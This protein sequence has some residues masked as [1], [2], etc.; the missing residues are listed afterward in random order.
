MSTLPG[1]LIEV[2]E[3]VRQNVE[4]VVADS[5]HEALDTVRH[6]ALRGEEKT[7]LHPPPALVHESKYASSSFL[8]GCARRV[9]LQ[10]VEYMEGRWKPLDSCNRLYFCGGTSIK[11]TRKLTRPALCFSEEHD[12]G[13]MVWVIVPEAPL[14]AMEAELFEPTPATRFEETWLNPGMEERSWRRQIG[15]HLR[16]KPVSE[17]PI[18]LLSGSYHVKRHGV[19]PLLRLQPPETSMDKEALET[20]CA[21]VALPNGGVMSLTELFDKNGDIAVCTVFQR[22]PMIAAEITNIERCSSPTRSLRTP[23]CLIIMLRLSARD[24]YSVGDLTTQDDSAAEEE[25]EEDEAEQVQDRH[26]N[27]L[28]VEH[29]EAAHEPQTTPRLLIK[30]PRSLPFAL[31]NMEALCDLKL[32]GRGSHIVDARN[33]AL[34]H[35]FHG[36]DH[37]LAKQLVVDQGTVPNLARHLLFL[38][39]HL[40]AAF[41]LLIMEL[42]PDAAFTNLTLLTKSSIHVDGDDVVRLLHFSNILPLVYQED[43]LYEIKVRGVRRTPLRLGEEARLRTVATPVATEVRDFMARIATTLDRLDADV[44]GLKRRRDAEPCDGP[45]RERALAVPPRRDESETMS[46]LKQALRLLS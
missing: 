37:D 23:L 10:D 33:M 42:G 2:A 8:Y 9:E 34:E 22:Q 4:E 15:A 32:V 43:I 5:R 12:G 24:Y 40:D 7:L 25:E 17:L 27:V 39:S 29:L 21:R 36:P 28:H 3:S 11:V 6:C 16:K 45:V 1:L 38:R 46:N 31:S 35:M 18:W 41:G 26:V 20:L 44:Q 19:L 13:L 14:G 30:E